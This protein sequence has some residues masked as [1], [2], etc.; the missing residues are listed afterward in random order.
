MSGKL[1]EGKQDYDER[2]KHSNHSSVLYTKMIFK[3]REPHKVQIYNLNSNA[4]LDVSC[5][6]KDRRKKVKIMWLRSDRPM[7]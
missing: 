7:T 3:V 6:L 5:R 4:K 1:R 2:A